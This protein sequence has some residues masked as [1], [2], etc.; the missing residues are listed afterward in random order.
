MSVTL[1]GSVISFPPMMFMDFGPVQNV[2]GNLGNM[3]DIEGVTSVV[4]G[5]LRIVGLRI[6]EE[7][8]A[9]FVQHIYTIV[10]KV[11]KVEKC[12]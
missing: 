11:I 4:E 6:D 12:R 1:S 2:I 9:E 7:A 5:A 3:F 8:P 10:A